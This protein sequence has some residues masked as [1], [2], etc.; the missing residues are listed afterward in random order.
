MTLLAYEAFGRRLGSSIPLPELRP[1]SPGAFQWCFRVVDS[2]TP[3]EEPEL[4]GEEPIYGSVAA[5][6]FRHRDGYRVTVDD[7]GVFDLSADGRTIRWLPNPEP[8]WDF[9]RSHLIGRILAMALQL[10]GTLTLHAS[11]VEMGDGVIAFL[12][13]KH[14]GKSTLALSLFRAGARFVTDD[15]L[16]VETASDVV[17]WP[18]V[19]SLRVRPGEADVERIL[20]E[21][22]T[23]APGRDGKA[24]LPPFPRD[25]VLDALRR[26]SAVYFLRPV[27]PSSGAFPVER[28]RLPRI[29]ATMRLLG[30]TKI[31]AMLG[32]TFAPELLEG[33]SRV[34]AEAP[35]YDLKL[36]RDLDR[37]PHAVETLRSWH[38]LPL[39]ERRSAGQAAE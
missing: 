38:G 34:A 17:A 18:G 39:G 31:G 14:F 20:G 32:S 30:M 10:E 16:A 27:D 7:T 28:I 23:V 5:R 8:W 22:V 36:V 19:Q 12:A 2:L 26:L 4:L 15:S 1:T 13:P 29:E 24:F 35:V 9:G 33:V 25:R 11:A 6:L 21:R 3:V 37:L